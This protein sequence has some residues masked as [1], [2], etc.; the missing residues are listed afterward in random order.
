[1]LVWF[2]FGV[3]QASSKFQRISPHSSTENPVERIFP[4]GVQNLK[5][6]I[7]VVSVETFWHSVYDIRHRLWLMI[8]TISRNM[9]SH[10]P[11]QLAYYYT[12]CSNYFIHYLF[13]ALC[14]IP[15]FPLNFT[16][17]FICCF[18]LDFYFD[19]HRAHL[20]KRILKNRIHDWMESIFL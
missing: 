3:Y 11:I 9:S 1:M 13:T 2:M 17:E 19:F 7:F 20:W 10:C 5:I 12:F 16:I 8:S 4:R 14:S 18:N 15:M 6:K